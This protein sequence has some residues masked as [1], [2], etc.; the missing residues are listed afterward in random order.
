MRRSVGASS[1]QSLAPVSGISPERKG[2]AGQ[3]AGSGVGFKPVGRSSGDH[4]KVSVPNESV[5]SGSS[6]RAIPAA[7]ASGAALSAVA[8]PPGGG[9]AKGPGSA[10]SIGGSSSS[11]RPVAAS[12]FSGPG[13]SAAP[14][15]N[16]LGASTRMAAAVRWEAL[17][18]R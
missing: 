6:F 13:K 16:E 3:T 4:P 12:A 2:A 7:A 18:D 11:L 10:T 1:S 17:R 9:A 8:S 5:P 15:T 14:A